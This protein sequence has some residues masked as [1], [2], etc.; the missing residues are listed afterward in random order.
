MWHICVIVV[1]KLQQSVLKMFHDSHPDINKM[2]LLARTFCGWSDIDQNIQKLAKTCTAW[3]SVAPTPAVSL[4]HY[5][6]GQVILGNGSKKIMMVYLMDARIYKLTFPNNQKF[7][8]CLV[9]QPY[10]LL[11]FYWDCQNRK[12]LE[13]DH[14]F[15]QASMIII[16]KRMVLITFISL[17][18]TQP[19]IV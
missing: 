9:Q 15:S 14:S 12:C 7:I 5:D 2:K 13:I 16:W 18:I 17:L 19:S 10:K 4:P 1:S 6:F 8:R 11:K 3:L